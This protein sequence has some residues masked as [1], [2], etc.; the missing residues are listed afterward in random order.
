LQ[1]ILLRVLEERKATKLGDHEEK[2]L[3]VRIIAAT[4]RNLEADVNSG[5]FRADLYYRLNVLQIRIPPLRDRK[6]DIAPLADVFLKQLRAQYG[7][8]PVDVCEEALQALTIHP[9]PGNVRELRNV[10]ER[11]FLLAVHEPIISL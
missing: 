10:I 4:N 5:R 2:P 9:W 3:D 6:E 8:G 7:T 11:A 1:V